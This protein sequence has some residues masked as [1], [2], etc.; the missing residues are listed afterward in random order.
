MKSA[1]VTGG[2]GFIGSHLVDRLIREGVQVTVLDNGST[3]HDQALAHWNPEQVRIIRWDVS[4]PWPGSALPEMVDVVFHLAS[5]ASPVQY[6][7]LPIETLMV[8]S[9]GT[10]NALEWSRT[11]RARLVFTST[12][13]VYGEPEVSPQAESY[14]GNVNPVGLRSCYDESKRFAEA[15]IMAHVRQYDV[16]ARI[17]RLFNCYGPRMRMNDGRVIPELMVQAL[18]GR[19]LTIY[20]T[21]EQTRS[22]C[23]V[24][25]EVEALLRAARV[26]GLAGEV[27]NIGNPDPRTILDVARMIGVMA[28][29][30][31]CF[32]FW[33]LP[34]DDPT[35]RCPDI[36]KAQRLL[37]WEPTIALGEGLDKTLAY[38]QSILAPG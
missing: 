38:F 4:N 9:L 21:G 5:P 26:D 18:T 2:L 22:F 25:D 13:E 33:D 28:G 6:H 16:D 34:P 29:R 31:L 3:G 30:D 35:N 36:A 1:I 32:T 20:G 27:I 24:S 15:L 14:W 8:N 11:Y 17:L 7:R 12:S 23:Y 37:E 10:K 19:P